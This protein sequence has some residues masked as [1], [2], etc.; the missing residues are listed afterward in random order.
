MKLKIFIF[1]TIVCA[2][3]NTK[4]VNTGD[5]YTIDILKSYP[6]KNI[7]LQSAADIE[8]VALETSDDVLLGNLPFLN[9]ISDN[10]IVVWEELGNIFIFNRNGEIIKRINNRGLG[11]GEYSIIRSLV[12]DE[13]TEEIFVYDYPSNHLFVYSLTGE[14]K[15]T[16]E[17]SKDLL[18]LRIYD[19]DNE[20]LLAYEVTGLIN[21]PGLSQIYSKK[22]YLFLSKK[23][24][25][26]VSSSDISLPIRLTYSVHNEKRE[27][28]YMIYY[29]DPFINN[30]ENYV[31]ADVSSDTIYKLNKNKDLTPFMNRRPSVH[32]SSLIKTFNAML[33]TDNFLLLDL[34]VFDFSR[35]DDFYDAAPSFMYEF[36][37]NSLS[38]VKFVNEDFPAGTWKPG[39]INI[40]QKNTTADMIWMVTLFEAYEKKQLKGKLEQLVATL[41]EYDN[42][43]VMITKFK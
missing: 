43:I 24:G 15:R 29:R 5:V 34:Y 2:G 11:P 18:W 4:T 35:I 3:C 7:S 8:Y 16:M 36:E 31:I 26:I 27:R 37:T 42:P 21:N 39:R 17:L 32:S 13:K 41:D 1:I 40:P 12:F 23:D 25:S 33:L 6:E 28:Y 22:P 14:Y 38:K 19:F 9:Y 30:G 20:T 10:Y